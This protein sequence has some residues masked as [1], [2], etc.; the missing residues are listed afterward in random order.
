VS[1]YETLDRKTVC[2]L[3]DSMPAGDSLTEV[4]EWLWAHPEADSIKVCLDSLG[5]LEAINE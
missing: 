2:A 4:L 5:R 3:A 1:K